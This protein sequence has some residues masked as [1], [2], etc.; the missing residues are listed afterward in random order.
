MSSLGI[1]VFS[2]ENGA[3]IT[4][5]FAAPRELF[6]HCSFAGGIYLSAH[7]REGERETEHILLQSVYINLENT[8]TII[9]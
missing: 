9:L 3:L 5:G 4:P 6:N 2:Q 7:W 1:S 8:I